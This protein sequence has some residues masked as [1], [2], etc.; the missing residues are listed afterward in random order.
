M[1]R[2]RPLR[3]P[4][5]GVSL[6]NLRPG[7]TPF[8]KEH[9]RLT[10]EAVRR[11]HGIPPRRE[12]PDRIEGAWRPEALRVARLNWKTRMVHEHESAAVFAGLLPQ[13]ME[14]NLPL[15]LK[16]T[17]TRMALDELFH[18]ELCGRV[19][20]ALGGEGVAEDDLRLTA[21]PTHPECTPAEAAL[22]NTLFA[23]CLSETVSMALLS[24]ERDRCAEPF[25]TEVLK[26]LAADEVSH[27]RIGWTVLEWIWPNLDGDAQARTRAYLP[28]ALDDLETQMLGAMPVADI[29]RPVLLEAEQL[30]FSDSN[31]AREILTQ[32]LD[33]VIRPRLDLIGVCR[34]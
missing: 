13:F 26:Q 10:L 31:K 25:I 14:A 12:Q 1:R 19:N 23:C 33:G 11:N 28:V 8:A 30:G 21:L 16:T 34:T 20:E 3:P 22:R 2:A 27:A 7:Q 18:A 5:H 9:R 15:E 24:A 32:T 4:P 6:L 29:P 17:V